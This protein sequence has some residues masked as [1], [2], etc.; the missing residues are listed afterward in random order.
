MTVAD[1]P[2]QLLHRHVQPLRVAADL[3]PLVVGEHLGRLVEVGLRRARRSPRREH[4]P[5]GR[6][7]GR[8][9]DA[10]RVV[11]DD[12]DDGVP[13]VLE[14]AELLQ[15]DR[16]A[17]VQVRRGGVQA[18]LDPQRPALGQALLER[19]FGRAP[20]RRCGRG[21]DAG[22]SIRA[23]ARVRSLAGPGPP[24]FSRPAL[25]LGRVLAL[26]GTPVDT[27][28]E[29]SRA[30]QHDS[31]ADASGRA[32]RCVEFPRTREREA[33]RGGLRLWRRPQAPEALQGPQAARPGRALL[34]RRPGGRLDRCSA[35][36]WRSRRTCRSSRTRRTRP[37]VRLS[38]QARRRIG[39]LTG[40]ERR[41]YLSEDADRRLV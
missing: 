12:Q 26:A 3:Q 5:G 10:R 29:R 37:A 16:V 39:T 33:Q 13:E 4:R 21:T 27:C 31:R 23:N 34:P 28:H 41:I 8:V 22:D 9:A 36:S 15:H 1:Q 17:E 32:P 30:N 6:A 7:P 2:E 18:E 19:P 25:T 24:A 14:L 38:R 20:R 11:A 35:C 40:N